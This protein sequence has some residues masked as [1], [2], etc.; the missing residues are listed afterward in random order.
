[1]NL[2]QKGL[3]YDSE[4]KRWTASYPW[5]RDP[6]VLPNNFVA[7]KARMVSTERRLLRIGADYA[8]LYHDQIRDMVKRKVA[9]KLSEREIDEYDGPVHYL[10][11]HEVLKPDSRSTPLRIVFNSSA[12]FMGHSLNDYWAKGPNIVN[13]LMS[14]LIRF[15]E[16][17]VGMA[18]DISKMYNSVKMSESDQ[19]THRFLWRDMDQGK[20]PDHYVMEAVTFG[21]RPSGAIASMAL[22]KTAE[23]AKELYPEVTQIIKENSYVDDIL[24][25]TDS[26]SA[27]KNLSEDIDVVLEKGGFKV[28]HWTLSGMS[29]ALGNNVNTQEKVLGMI[30]DPK[31]DTFKYKARLNFSPKVK[32]IHQ[33][34]N[35]SEGDIPNQIPQRLTHR[36]VLSQVS[37]IFDPLGL[38][39][40]FILCAKLLMRALCKRDTVGETGGRQTW[41]SAM[42]E[43]M[44]KEWIKFFSDLFVVETLEFPRCIKPDCVKG[45]PILI[46][47]SDGSKEAFGACAYIRWETRNEIVSTNLIAAKNR[48]APTRQLS[49][50]RLELCGAVIGVRLREKL[51]NGSKLRFERVFHIVDSMIVQAQIQK[52]SYGFGTFT[53]T[54][55]AEI[56]SKSSPDEW[57]WVSGN[58]NPA[59]LTTRVTAPKNLDMESVWQ[60]GPAFLKMPLEEW[61]ISRTF[62]LEGEPL[63]DIIGHVAVGDISIVGDACRSEQTSLEDV[64]LECFKETRTLFRVTALL[65]RIVKRGTLRQNAKIISSCEIN[66]AE[67]MWIKYTQNDMRPDWKMAY[68]RLGVIRNPDGFIVV[69]SRLS[70]WMKASWNQT[71]FILLPPKAKFTELVMKSCHNEDHTGVEA[72]LAKLR[73]KYWVPGARKFLKMIKRQCVT[74][75]RKEKIC[76]T[77]AM[78][79]LP[80]DRLRPSPAFSFTAVDLFGLFTI[81]DTV[82]KRTHGKAYGVIFTCLASRGVY[83]DLADSYSTDGFMMVL[84]RFVSLRGYPKKLR[85]DCGTQLVAASKVLSE[86]DLNWQQIELFGVNHGLEWEFNK[87]A[88]SPWENGCCESLIKSVKKCLA[89]A[90]GDSVMSFTELQTVLFEAANSLN[91]RP[92]GKKNSD[93]N[94]GSYLCP[95]DLLLGRASIRVPPGTWSTKESFKVRWKF[96]QQVVDV[97]WKRWIRDFFPTL[98]IRQ[99]W[100]TSK[101]NLLV[102]DIVLVQDSN[103]VRGQ[104][105]LAQ[106]C[107][108]TPGKDGK[109]RDVELRYKS[110]DPGKGYC[111]TTDSIIRRSV[112]RLVLILPVEEQS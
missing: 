68:Q 98:I 34:Q 103:A 91:E 86:I 94:E 61:P 23:L 36:M 50:P 27:A 1:M 99:K 82:K 75:R 53:A 40:P 19:H 4:E 29:T 15:R 26:T 109:V 101:R 66:E 47:F 18:G 106:V 87:S 102:G 67:R 48:I 8:K 31:M 25:S 100:H 80:L 59:D 24:C 111:G 54:R 64:N 17:Q 52:E 76:H 90:I 22:L 6:G 55:V 107:E 108:A 56:Q 97:F 44:R 10:P 79:S 77:Q 5:I 78:R 32:K 43:D 9:R 12:S 71:E 33:E 3:N 14:V 35:L 46:V 13:D 42:D 45:N 83:L 11:H 16:G 57:W 112:H 21:D 72:T 7:A 60:T 88:D 81:R 93:P 37:S 65:M 62:N 92:I 95:N 28:K 41:D 74:C 63:P 105:K 84:R 2:I 104:W 30:W 69:G 49:I 85:S 58:D 89:S 96:V 38:I 73:S 39:T 110:Q 70:E 20:E 51:L